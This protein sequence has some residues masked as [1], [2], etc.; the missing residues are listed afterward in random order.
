MDKNL[1]SVSN[2]TIHDVASLLV[3]S[4]PSD[5]EALGV[6]E[7]L[8]RGLAARKDM[9]A[10]GSRLEEAAAKIALA[11]G[12]ASQAEELLCLAGELIEE[13]AEGQAGPNQDGQSRAAVMEDDTVFLDGDMDHDLLMSFAAEGREYLEQAEEAL[14]ILEADPDARESCNAV[15]RAFHTIKGTSAFLNLTPITEL[16][17]H[18]ESLL[19]QVRDGRFRYGGTYADLSLRCVDTLQSMLARLE[20]LDKQEVASPP[21]LPEGYHQLMQALA[22]AVDAPPGGADSG[23]GQ[24]TGGGADASGLEHFQFADEAAGMVEREAADSEAGPT[25]GRGG[26]DRDGSSRDSSDRGGGNR[27]GSDRGGSEP[28]GANADS[29][30]RVRTERLDRVL[31]NIGEL[32]IAHSM[33]S[34]DE[35]VRTSAGSSLAAKLGQAGKIVREL[36]SLSMSLRMVPLKSVFRK[37]S[38][39]ARD[40]AGK[41][42]KLVDFVAEG[43]DTEV[44]RTMVELV[45]DPL[46]HMLRNALDH[47]IEPPDER[48][49]AGKPQRGRVRL[50]ASHVGGDV[51]LDLSDDGRGLDRDVIVEKALKRGLIQTEKGL[52]ENEILSLIFEPGFS[53]AEKVTDLS[54]RGVGMDVVRRNVESLNGRVE[55]RSEPGMGTGFSIRLPLTLAVTDGMLVQVAEERFILPTTNIEL[56]LRAEA[57]AVTR[58]P[59]KGELLE[60]RGEFL[61]ILRLSNLL[62][63]SGAESDPARSILVVVG[64]ADRRC[65][66]MVDQLLGQQQ[67]VA[68]SLGAGLSRVPGIAGGAIMGD[69]RVGLILDLPTIVDLSRRPGSGDLAARHAVGSA[70]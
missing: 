16:A 38:R 27:D 66:L 6:V 10:C 8:L 37:L 35:A 21:P 54:G 67:V 9:A 28:S 22:D 61:P 62:A 17:H 23:C 4:D 70:A 64:V 13:V 30:I 32:V 19:S 33:I 18:A 58:L 41:H 40:V 2:C 36:Q 34:Q 68:K 53:T 12:D 52:S 55:L 57:D 14:L 11:M 60:L 46:V 3:Q 65:A 69:G 51:V 50:C 26:S 29:W 44:D 43:E 31:D 7:G 45:T 42:G 56:S 63:I 39:L 49:A 5:V 25:P 47:G 15:F 48:Q 24:E 59:G 1:P 20:K